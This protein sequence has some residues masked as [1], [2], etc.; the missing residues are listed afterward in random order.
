M[1]Y[2]LLNSGLK[3]LGILTQITSFSSVNQL[4]SVVIKIRQDRLHSIL[5]ARRLLLKSS[6]QASESPTKE[7]WLQ[8]H[9]VDF[10]Q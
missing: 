6:R 5:A 3:F 8:G 2:K 9:F 7:Y 1:I 4:T 10:G